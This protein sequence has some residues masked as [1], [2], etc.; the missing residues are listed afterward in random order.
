MAS[1]E[2]L[3]SAVRAGTVERDGRVTLRCSDA[4]QIA[5]SLSASLAEIGQICNEN[6]IRIVQCQLGCFQ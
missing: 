2:E 5:D 1:H 3:V 4:F 6:G